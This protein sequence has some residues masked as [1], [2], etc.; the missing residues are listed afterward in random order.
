[1]NVY[2]RVIS[3]CFVFQT[4]CWPRRKI[5]TR[6]LMLGQIFFSFPLIS[7]SCAVEERTREWVLRDSFFILLG[8]D[9][10]LIYY[11]AF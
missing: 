10:S 6:L 4:I 7:V 11:V 8:T 3:S 1:M 2:W 9:F 5:Q